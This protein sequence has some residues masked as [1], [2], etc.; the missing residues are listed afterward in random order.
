MQK[1]ELHSGGRG[2][3]PYCSVC[4]H[5]VQMRLSCAS[6]AELLVKNADVWYNFHKIKK[7]T[8]TEMQTLCPLRS[9]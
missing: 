3:R 1:K 4:Y 5:D 9:F 2:V 6:L 7:N 8:K